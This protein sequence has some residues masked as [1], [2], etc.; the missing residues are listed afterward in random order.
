MT[1]GFGIPEGTKKAPDQPA[2][3]FTFDSTLEEKVVASMRLY[4]ITG[5]MGRHKWL[6][7]VLAPVGALV[8]FLLLQGA[9]L[10][11]AL[12][13]VFFAIVYT[14]LHLALYRRDLARNIRRHLAR[15]FRTREPIPSEYVIDDRMVSFSN[16]GT[17][18]SFEWRSVKEV[19]E[20]ADAVE[21][22][23][24]PA[25]IARIPHRLFED[26]AEKRRLLEF[27]RERMSAAGG[28]G[29]RGSPEG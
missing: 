3:R 25:G 8:C 23:V 5:L 13:G 15:Q 2:F 28:A 11:R 6:P 22:I 4:E 17:T 10:P 19:I 20:A 26:P 27:A 1:D 9:A 12:G 18:I 21:L 24:E 16:L 7:L 14:I 29:S